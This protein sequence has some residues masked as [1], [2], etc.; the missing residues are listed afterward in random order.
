M[1]TNERR[2]RQRY[3]AASLNVEIS[4]LN[5]LGRPKKTFAVN[6]T[7]NFA[8]GGLSVVSPQKLKPGQ[9]LMLTIE[10][11]HHRL[12]AVPAI[13]LRAEQVNHE[14]H[15]ALKFTL[16]ELSDKASKAAYAVLQLLELSL[17]P[18]RAA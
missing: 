12:Q 18:A 17:K 8:I 5:W 16:G 9:R 3:T 1:Q 4:P 15:C 11:H 14:Y 2:F 13:V 6:S 10:S 7:R